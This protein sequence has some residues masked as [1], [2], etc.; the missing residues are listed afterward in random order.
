MCQVLSTHSTRAFVGKSL[1]K[2]D[3]PAGKRGSRRK[4]AES[5]INVS[6]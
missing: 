4:T 5:L 1:V 3:Q 6:F 2:Y